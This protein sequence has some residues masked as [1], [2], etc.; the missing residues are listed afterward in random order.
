MILTSPPYN[1]NKKAGKARTLENTTW[2][3]NIAPYVRYDAYSDNMTNDEYNE[4]TVRLFDEFDRILNLNGVVLYNISYGAENT[5]GMF[6]AINAIIT[7]TNMTLAD[8]IC[9]EK[10]CSLPNNCSPNRLTRAWEFVLVFCRKGEEKTF[11][12]NKRVTSKRDSGQK[13]YEN[14]PNIIRAKNNDGPNPYNKA[15]Y[16]VELCEKLLSLYAP[17]GG[18]VYD[19]FMGTGTTAIACINM[20][21]NYMGSEISTRQCEYAGA[22]IE[23]QKA[24]LTLFNCDKHF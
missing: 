20:G 1:T 19:P 4:F 14:I 21:L 24:Q 9:W 22:R 15:T 7:R 17:R 18:Y 16:S 2:H 23:Q 8:V 6:E 3:R 5:T 10:Q 13:M 12:M 11:Y